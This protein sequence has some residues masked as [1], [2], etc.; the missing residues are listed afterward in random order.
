MFKNPINNTFQ[1]MLPNH[2]IIE[3]ENIS[4]TLLKKIVDSINTN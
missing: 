4:E 3:E 1:M 2:Q